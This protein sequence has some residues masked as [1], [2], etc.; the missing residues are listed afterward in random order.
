MAE[1]RGVVAQ[2]P[3][4]VG[5]DL[6]QQ[7]VITSQ[8]VGDAER[9]EQTVVIPPVYMYAMNRYGQPP[10]VSL[11]SEAY[12]YL[13]RVM[14]VQLFQPMYVNDKDGKQVLNPIHRPD[15]LYVRLVGVWRNDLG[16]M[17]SYR[18]DVEVD[19]NLVYQDARI[20]AKSAKVATDKEGVPIFE[21]GIP[22]LVLTA[23]DEL[24][25]LKALSQ[26]R[27]FGLR[28]AQTVAKT[29]IL[30]T[31]SGISTLPITQPQPFAVRVVGFR[32]YLT[33]DQRNAQA[34]RD[35]KSMFGQGSVLNE[36]AGLT[37]DEIAQIQD[38][39]PDDVTEDV[40]RELVQAHVEADESHVIDG[41][42]SESF[43]APIRRVDP[44]ADGMFDATP[45][46]PPTKRQ[47]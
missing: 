39:E 26:L 13:N 28:Y 4:Q 29:R 37:P 42:E 24:R 44:D 9:I 31:A 27:T 20:N 2:S 46:R 11:T 17:V 14:G 5:L 22:R 18:E 43:D 30:K 32:D 34:E 8:M 1:E 35:L 23:E 33:P 12:N 10:K 15:Y 21:N 16:Q 45:D 38:F 19:Y 47:R 7:K 3:Q 36:S 40:E 25:A 6:P 41:H